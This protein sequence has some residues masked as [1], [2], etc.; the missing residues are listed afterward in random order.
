[1]H[2]SCHHHRKNY[3]GWL[4]MH[5]QRGFSLLLVLFVILILSLGTAMFMNR[6]GDDMGAGASRRDS[7]LANGLAEAAANLLLSRFIADD[8]TVADI[9]GN[10]IADRIEGYADIGAAPAILN[11]TYAFYGQSGNSTP[12]I[13]RIATGESTGTSS[14]IVNQ[15]IPSSTD[16]MLVNNLFVSNTIKP[17]LYKQNGTGLSP[18]TSTWA[19]EPSRNKA[20][21]WFEYEQNPSHSKWADVYVAAAAQVGNARGYVRRYVGSYT[22]ELGGMVSPITESAIH[23]G[24]DSTPDTCTIC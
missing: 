8:V 9:D 14:S 6:S 16:L 5:K 20:A 19:D 11:I 15:I 13:Q 18:S 22:D 3:L 2:V 4:S 23:A 12:P 10:G 21:I 7:E 17:I 24:G 1:M